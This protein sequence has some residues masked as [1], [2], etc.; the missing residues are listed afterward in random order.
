MRILVTAD[1]VGGVWTYARELV[2]HLLRHGHEVVLVSFG[3]L[4]PESQTRWMQPGPR[5]DFR[6]TTYKLEWMQNSASD[7]E[8]SSEYLLRVID[9]TEPD[10]LHLNQYCYGSLDCGVP[11]IV[12]AHSD[13]VSWWMNTRGHEPD[14]GTWV[15]AYRD[16]VTRGIAGANA[17]VGVTHWMLQ[18][19]S[20]YYTE[21]AIK[22]VIY[23]GRSP[24]LFAPAA[25][26]EDFALTGG[27][28]WDEAKQAHLLTGRVPT[29]DV[30]IVG[31]EEHPE[32]GGA[33]KPNSTRVKFLGPQDEEHMRDL[34]SRAGIYIAT[35]RY[36][37]FGLAPLEAALSGCAILANDIES[38][39]EVWDDAVLYFSRNDADDL[40]RQLSRLSENRA[41]RDDFSGR[42]YRRAVD[43]YSAE[44]MV[45]E[46]LQLYAVLAGAGSVVA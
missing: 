5:L 42:A 30:C 25:N 17:V 40:F 8:A 31:A 37:P 24:E 45:S 35:S 13:V 22:K 28:L 18:Q 4:P 20:T 14:P 38:L 23:N 33:Q 9:E 7:L 39:R 10:L 15:D 19:I 36:E 34:Y 43:F 6:P 3:G 41:L 12:V 26:K 46:Y 27:R 1:T 21:P 29:I 44:K 2:T 11:K 16:V 32:G